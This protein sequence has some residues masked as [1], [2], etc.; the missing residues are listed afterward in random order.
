MY[1]TIFIVAIF[2]LL[3]LGICHGQSARRGYAQLK[4]LTADSAIYKLTYSV[5]I[6]RD[7]TNRDDVLSA[8]LVTLVGKR[9][10]KAEDYYTFLSDSLRMALVAQ[11]A[12]N[13]EIMQQRL[14]TQRSRFFREEILLD[15][16]SRGEN[17]FQESVS[18]N[19]DRV[20]DKDACQQWQLTEETREILGYECRKAICSF[21]G[22]D[23]EAWYAEDQPM[24][25]GPYYFQGLPGLIIQLSD[26]E[27]DYKFSLIGLVK[28]ETP[29]P[30]TLYDD[31]GVEKVSREDFKFLKDYYNADRAAAFISEPNI[32][33]KL[34]PEMVKRLNAYRPYN[35]IERE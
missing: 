31:S 21:R 11:G 26:T 22:R 35:P 5:D 33:M 10:A 13:A 9:S 16:P 4:Y 24:P 34:T 32:K 12:S 3:S 1:K 20:Y 27:G 2:S 14:Q 17:I 7:T 30:L 18:G 15:Y 6:V 8:Y 28:F 25:R 29:F 19:F 23:Y